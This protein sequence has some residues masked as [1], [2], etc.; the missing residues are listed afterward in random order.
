MPS[1]KP[2]EIAVFIA[3]PG[4]LAPERKTFKD[5][6]DTLNRGFA[7]G[8]GVRFVA[9]GWEDV[10]S[11]TGRRPQSVIN[12]DVDRCDFF[13]LALHRRW[14]QAAPDSRYSSYTEEEFQ[15]ACKRWE[16]TKSPE[17]VVFFKTVDAASL[18]DP[19]PELKKVMARSGRN[20]RAVAGPC[21][22]GQ[23]RREPFL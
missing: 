7:D 5:V 8:A 18:A 6:I 15:L 4:D 2:R 10:L 14:G 21:F 17:V 13:V 11:E 20:L 12:R 3:S 1:Q 23:V 9:L 16:K 19:G 22:G